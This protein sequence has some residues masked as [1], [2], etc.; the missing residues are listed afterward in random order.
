MWPA[1]E[2]ALSHGGQNQGGLYPSQI[3][4]CSSSFV[5]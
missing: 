5:F 1:M 2:V 3:E 4:H